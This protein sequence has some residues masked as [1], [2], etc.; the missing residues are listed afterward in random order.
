VCGEVV[1]GKEG[2]TKEVVKEDREVKT[3]VGKVV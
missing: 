2:K 1:T 3:V